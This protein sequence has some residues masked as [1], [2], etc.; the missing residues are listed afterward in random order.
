MRVLIVDDDRLLARSIADLLQEHR[1]ETDVAYD[2]RTGLEAA[3]SDRYDLMILDVM[4][5]EISGFEIAAYLRSAGSETPI[6]ML[7][8][9][10]DVSDRVYGLEHGADCY[11]PKPF[12]AAELLAYIK[13]LLRRQGIVQNKLV[14]GNTTLDVFTSQLSA[15]GL[16]VRLSAR[17]FGLMRALMTAK[18]RNISKESLL[19]KVWGYDANAS[20]NCVEV[21][22]SLLR[23]KLAAIGSDVVICAI[24]RQGYHLEV[25]PRA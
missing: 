9:R 1:F 5:P 19:V 14:Y 21:Y 6:I 13:S 2:G 12:H 3:E 24:L 11:L 7:T 15:A 25:R 22:V 8:A 17:E 4:L 16:S 18:H 20:E 23:K 10:G